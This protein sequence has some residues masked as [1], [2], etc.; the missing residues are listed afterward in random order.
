MGPF[1]QLFASLSPLWRVP[2]VSSRVP[3][4]NKSIFRSEFVRTAV[5]DR[6]F[7]ARL[8]DTTDGLKGAETSKHT[9]CI[10]G[11]LF[12]S[13]SSRQILPETPPLLGVDKTFPF[14]VRTVGKM[15]SLENDH[16]PLCK[17]PSQ[18]R[19]NHE[20]IPPR[21]FHFFFFIFSL[22]RT[23]LYVH[24]YAC[25]SVVFSLFCFGF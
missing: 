18:G 21:R 12:L 6:S 2:S 17:S 9:G 19:D 23:C 15:D 3:S 8:F 5:Y 20:I 11:R 14:Y 4:V 7:G 13:L 25:T 1:P 16:T 22:L 10:L 24:R